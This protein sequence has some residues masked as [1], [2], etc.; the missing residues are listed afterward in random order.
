[1]KLFADLHV[2]TVASGHAYSTVEEIARAAAA[3][4]LSMVALADHGP[5]MPGGPFEYHF[6]NLRVLPPV[7]HGVEVLHG[8][9]ANILD[10]QGTL[11]LRE[12]F[13]KRLDIVLAGLH[14]LCLS[15][16]DREQN[17]Q[18]LLNALRNPYVDI[19]VHPGNPDFPID[20]ERVVLAARDLGKALEINNSSFFVRRGSDSVCREIAGLLR[21]HG[22]LVS[23]SSDAHTA[24]D[25][26]ELSRAMELVLEAGIPQQ[27]ILNQS[28]ERVKQFLAGRGKKRFAARQEG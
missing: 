8:V 11:D 20:T 5:A 22:C 27:S 3:R 26:G 14:T 6:A 24:Y 15:P 17:T 23:V 10:A 12:A 19:I 1:M 9:E 28:A 13:L 25:V 21:R 2:H 18:A 16:M 4:G 7:I